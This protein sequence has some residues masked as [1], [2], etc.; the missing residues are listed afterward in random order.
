MKLTKQS[1]ALDE[2]LQELFLVASKRACTAPVEVRV[3]SI[4]QE[5]V[6]KICN[7]RFKEFYSVQ[8]EKKLIQEGKVVSADQSLRDKLKTYSVDKCA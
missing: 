3:C 7:T 4:W 6:K 5:L 8:E 1:V 2:E